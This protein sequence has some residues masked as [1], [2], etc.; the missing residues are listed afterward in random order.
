MERIDYQKFVTMA[1]DA[2]WQGSADTME[3]AIEALVVQ[4]R[5]QAQLI[6]DGPKD[7]HNWTYLK[8][9]EKAMSYV[10]PMDAEQV[11]KNYIRKA[12]PEY[13]AAER[14]GKLMQPASTMVKKAAPDPIPT[15]MTATEA[16]THAAQQLIQKGMPPA[17][18]QYQAQTEHATWYPQYLRESRRR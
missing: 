15:G 11:H 12:C 8:T 3:A 17:E 2:V 16:L 18:A 1:K 4:H 13:W 5:P 14:A 6:C 10:D 9:I 7:V